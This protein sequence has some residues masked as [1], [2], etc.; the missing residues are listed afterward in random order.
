MIEF[1]SLVPGFSL[2][3]KSL[4]RDW[5]SEIILKEGKN[6][7]DLNLIFCNDDYLLEIN[8]N[9][10][11]HDYYTDI[12]TFS[13]SHISAIISGDIYIS[14]DRVKEN[15]KNNNEIFEMELA[16]VLAHGLLHLLGYDDNTNEQVKQMRTKED[17]YLF[18]LPDF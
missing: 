9:Y 18:L 10:L 2:F 16:R 5:L 1:N 8:R 17:I 6:P 11:K 12:I 14:I 15:A 13:T 4:I 3:D 7:G